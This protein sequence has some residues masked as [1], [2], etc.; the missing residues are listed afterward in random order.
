MCR[1]ILLK[2]IFSII[3]VQSSANLGKQVSS[4]EQQ[5]G[6]LNLS[7]S[8]EDSGIENSHKDR[9]KQT[10]PASRKSPIK[11]PSL[12]DPL[13]KL[14]LYTTTPPKAPPKHND[15]NQESGSY[16]Q[17]QG[18]LTPVKLCTAS[19]DW[20]LHKPI[21][22]PTTKSTVCDKSTANAL[23]TSADDQQSSSSLQ[24]RSH[25]PHSQPADVIT[26]KS[27]HNT[28]VN[29]TCDSSLRSMEFTSEHI[30]FNDGVPCVS[31]KSAA[32]TNDH[33]SHN[34][35]NKDDFGIVMPSHSKVHQYLDSVSQSPQ[36]QGLE[37]EQIK[38]HSRIDRMRRTSS[39][40][41]A[42]TTSDISTASFHTCRE[43]VWVDSDDS[44]DEYMDLEDLNITVV[45]NIQSP[46]PHFFIHG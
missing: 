25:H 4:L 33:Q 37:L 42:S 27:L 2:L 17:S 40:S 1:I 10:P 35:V 5:L 34:K 15:G 32:V 18:F 36:S 20:T 19:N 7:D 3:Q 45:S 6:Q 44:S 31:A 16:A 23:S 28:D 24:S 39:C 41:D 12:K 38:A 13:P 30:S 43:N 14:V 11:L 46:P 21:G 22:Q 29:A 8:G 9:D 26:T